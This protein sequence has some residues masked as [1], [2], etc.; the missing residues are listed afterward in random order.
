MGPF[1]PCGNELEPF[2][3]R[4]FTNNTISAVDIDLHNLKSLYNP[5]KRIK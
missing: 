5:P 1:A 2:E 4:V 3:I